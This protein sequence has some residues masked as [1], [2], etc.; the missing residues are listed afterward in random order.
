MIW[1][2]QPTEIPDLRTIRTMV[3]EGTYINQGRAVGIV[4]GSVSYF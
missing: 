1:L 2:L 4:Y 3:L